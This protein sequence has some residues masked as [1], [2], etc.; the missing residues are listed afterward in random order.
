[1]RG[2][3]HGEHQGPR[4]QDRPDRAG[5]RRHGLGIPASGEA[6]PADDVWRGRPP[7]AVQAV[8]VTVQGRTRQSVILTGMRVDVTSSRPAPQHGIVVSYGQCGGGVDVRH[9]DLDLSAVPPTYTAK[10]ADNFGKITPAVEFP[11]T[12]SLDDAEVFELVPAKGCG[13]NKD[14]TYTVTLQWVADGKV[15]TTVVNNHGQGFRDLSPDRLP[16]YHQDPM[17]AGGPALRPRS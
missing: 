8:Q 17:S 3:Q 1:V 2:R 9:F 5:R 12:I 11:Y 13:K 14:C 4:Q 16:A 10:P 7:I 15:G 6:A